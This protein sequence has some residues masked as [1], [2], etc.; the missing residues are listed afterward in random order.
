M[1]VLERFALDC[2]EKTARQSGISLSRTQ[3]LSAM[4]L[5]SSGF[6]KRVIPR[7]AAYHQVCVSL[8]HR[9]NCQTR[10]EKRVKAVISWTGT[11][12]ARP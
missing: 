4:R 5:R 8:N 11:S 12:A 10:S 3:D 9:P 6:K 7:Q 2:L 1:D